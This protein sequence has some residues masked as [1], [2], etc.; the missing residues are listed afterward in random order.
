VPVSGAE[1]CHSHNIYREKDITKKN[2]AQT[3]PPLRTEA[4]QISFSFEER[5]FLHID[6]R[7]LS[8]WKEAYPSIDINLELKKMVEWCLSNDKKSKSK[9]LWRKFITN[10]L[11]NANEKAINKQSIQNSN[12]KGSNFSDRRTKNKDGSPVSS[13]YDG[14]F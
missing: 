13:E 11:S 1:K 6:E 12:A 7:D 4:T 9:K 14:M 10:W 2:T 8:Q 5:K 3:A